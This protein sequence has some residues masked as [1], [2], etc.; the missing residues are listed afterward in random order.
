MDIERRFGGIAR[1]YGKEASHKIQEARFT[2]IGVGGVGSWAAEALARTGVRRLTLIDMDVVAES[3]TNRQLQA[4]E[5]EFG[6]NKIDVLADRF[7]KINPEIEL[8]LVDDFVTEENAESLICAASGIVL[9]CIDQKKIKAAIAARAKS[10]AVPLITSGAAGGRKDP[11]RI[12]S[13]DLA[14]TAGDPLLSKVRYELRKRYGFPAGGSSGAGRRFGITAVYSDEP[15][16]ASLDGSCGLQ[17]AGGLQCAGYGSS[18]TVTSCMGMVCAAEALK[19]VL[20][21][22]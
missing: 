16:T 14:R 9:D 11:L 7:K 20:L 13:G 3:N 22:R 15:V 1:L 18:V 19:C 4:L 12:R 8:T 2:V 21:K 5:G 6:K 10:C 17:S